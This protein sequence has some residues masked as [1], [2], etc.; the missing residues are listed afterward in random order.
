MHNR[1][2]RLTGA[3]WARCLNLDTVPEPPV[4]VLEK[5]RV[6]LYPCRA[7]PVWL[8]AGAPTGKAPPKQPNEALP[9]P[10]QAKAGGKEKG[11][12]TFP[13]SL[14]LDLSYY[15]HP[16]RLCTGTV[17]PKKPLQVP[18]AGKRKAI[19]RVDCNVDTPITQRPSLMKTQLRLLM[20]NLAVMLPLPYQQKVR[21]A[22][23]F[24]SAAGDYNTLIYRQV[25]IHMR[26]RT[27]R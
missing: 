16:T 20:Q 5:P 6:N 14:H 27:P 2:P 7:S 10:V 4:P 15:L 8:T 18:Q 13:R 23:A 9:K 1:E 12:G 25:V 21:T 17:V 3:V 19:L 24:C 22:F 26:T 11:E